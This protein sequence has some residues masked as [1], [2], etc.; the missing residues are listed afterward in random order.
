MTNAPIETLR[1]AFEQADISAVPAVKQSGR[2]VVLSWPSVPIEI[3]RAA[4]LVPI[5]ARGGL[6]ATTTADAYLEHGIFPGRLRRLAEAALT[7]RV[8][9]AARILVPR[10]SDA[11]YKFFLYLREFVRLGI[12]PALPPVL[13]FDLLQSEGS[14]VASYNAARCRD[15]LDQLRQVN[16]PSVTLDD[17]RHE[18]ARANV[19][20]AAARRLI[21]LRRGMPR[22]SGAEVL[23]LLGAFWTADPDRYVAL[24]GAAAEEIARRA[25]LVG[26]RVLLAGAPVDGTSLHSAIETRGG[27]V[28]SE[29]S[30]WGNWA[31]GVDVVCDNDPI[32]ALAAKYRADIIGPR[33][34]VAQLR[35]SIEQVLDDVDLVVVSLP[36][37]DT[38]FGW[39]YP[40]LRN[41]LQKRGIPHACLFSNSC[42]PVSATDQER[43]DMLMTSVARAG[44]PRG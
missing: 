40:A 17:V 24:A 43:L 32:T 30:P 3:V 10:T 22:I 26:P 7:G 34:P 44:V 13:L 12:A 35:R 5:I 39:D 27:V 41:L 28:V 1:A 9:S 6:S 2:V 36:A 21:A 38:A 42:G 14:D 29:I 31:A 19:A 23:P 25:P 16:N 37:E 18:I 11:D 4:G 20:R 33:T 8:S 15:L